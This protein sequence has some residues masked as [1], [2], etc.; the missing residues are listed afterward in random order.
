MVVHEEIVREQGTYPRP[1]ASADRLA[2]LEDRPGDGRRFV[3]SQP[4]NPGL[5]RRGEEVVGGGT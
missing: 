5:L 2:E 1:L 3:A 4:A